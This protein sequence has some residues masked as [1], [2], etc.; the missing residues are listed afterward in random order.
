MFDNRLIKG[1]VRTFLM[2]AFFTCTQVLILYV[3]A[4][5]YAS[6]PSFH[7]YMIPDACLLP[8][9][10]ATAKVGL[11]SLQCYTII[12]SKPTLYTLSSVSRS[13]QL[14]RSSSSTA[15]SIEVNLSTISPP[16]RAMPSALGHPMRRGRPLLAPTA[17]ALALNNRHATPRKV[18]ERREAPTRQM[19]LTLTR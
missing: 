13:K 11:S 4:F 7:D 17:T 18:S 8:N 1:D 6:D 2:N 12:Y 3:Y 19:P 16:A 5:V 9:P 15:S 14:H 10:P